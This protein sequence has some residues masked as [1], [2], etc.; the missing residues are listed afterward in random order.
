M[1]QPAVI[2][3][4]LPVSCRYSAFKFLILGNVLQEFSKVLPYTWTNQTF[5]LPRT[6]NSKNVT[7]FGQIL[8]N[9]IF[10][11]TGDA[12]IMGY[13]LALKTDNN[14]S[15]INFTYSNTT[16]VL[17]G[18]VITNTSYQ[19]IYTDQGGKSNYGLNAFADL[20]TCN[21]SE[22]AYLDPNLQIRTCCLNCMSCW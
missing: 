8:L 2:F 6:N 14:N 19:V 17:D 11:I 1:P 3:L 15:C 12:D 10:N 4:N 7:P 21:S 13:D 5:F 16:S 22:K 20:F 18:L 9:P